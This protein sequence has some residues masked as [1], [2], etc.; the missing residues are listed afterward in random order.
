MNELFSLPVL[1]G[2]LYSG[3]R[4]ATPYLYAAL[5][6]MMQTDIHALAIR[7]QAPEHGD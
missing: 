5:G 7:A 4:L 2:V 1:L 3:V 6:E